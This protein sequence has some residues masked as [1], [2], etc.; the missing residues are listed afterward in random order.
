MPTWQHQ[1][2]INEL[3][4]EIK[5]LK[6]SK[7]QQHNPKTEMYRNNTNSESKSENTASVSH[8]GQ[9]ENIELMTVINFKRKLDFILTQEDK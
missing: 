2:E 1:Q 8:R 5:L 9:Q 7:K 4:E 6:Q 3:K